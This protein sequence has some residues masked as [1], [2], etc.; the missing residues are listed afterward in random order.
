[1]T[2]VSRIVV[3]RVVRCPFSVAHEYAAGFFR[4]AADQGAEVGVPLRD[5]VPT[6]GGRLREPVQIEVER[7]P[8]EAEPGRGHDAFVVGWTAGTRFFPDFHGALRLRIVSV[9]ETLLSLEGE[10]RP[11]FG[12]PGAA[13]DT[14]IGRRIARATMRDLLDRLA[15]AIEEHEVSL[16]ASTPQP[17]VSGTTA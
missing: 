1:V 4:Q 9:D 2:V 8:D 11:P 15:G 12:A 3:E 7:R 14:L 6:L 17:E 10:Y 13:F 5:L 16:R